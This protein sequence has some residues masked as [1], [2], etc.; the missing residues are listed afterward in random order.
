[1]TPLLLVAAGI[2]ALIAGALVLRSFGPRFRVGRL[3]AT[4]PAA[5]VDEALAMAERGE[6]RYV[7]LRGR[8]DAEEEFQDQD[9]R[10]LVFRRTR[11]EASRAGRWRAFE[12]NR[13]QVPFELREG[14][15]G[16]AIDGDALDA[17][18]VVV[19]RVSAGVA[20]DLGERAPGDLPG[21]TPVRATIEQVS[22]VEH[23]VVLGVPVAAEGAARMTAGLGRPLVLTTLE[24]DEAMRILSG[25]NAGRSRAAAALLT[26]GVGLMGLGGLWAVVEAVR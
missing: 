19:P 6:R 25:G 15:A 1:V 10:P 17:G 5:S 3:L 16:I 14:L 24:S 2:G 13:E 22:S 12:D 20:A 21:D 9:H 7:R 23:A 18:L 4:T 8:I 26:I 11:L